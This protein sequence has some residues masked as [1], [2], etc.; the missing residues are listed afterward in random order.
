MPGAA[1]HAGQL[2]PVF[3]VSRSFL[4]RQ[5]H[6]RLPGRW[7][8]QRR[9]KRQL[10][11]DAQL[12]VPVRA[13]ELAV[14]REVPVALL[15]GKDT[16]RVRCGRAA[17]P[18][19]KRGLHARHSSPYNEPQHNWRWCRKCQGLFFAEM[20]RGVCPAGGGHDPTGSANYSITGAGVEANEVHHPAH[21]VLTRRYKSCSSTAT[22]HWVCNTITGRRQAHPSQPAT[23]TAIKL[24]GV[25]HVVY[26]GTD[27]Q[28]HALFI[29]STGR[30]VFDTITLLAG[31]PKAAGNPF[32]YQATGGTSRGVSRS[33]QPH[34]RAVHRFDGGH[35]VFNN[36][37][38]LR[39]RATGGGRP[40][41]L[42]RNGVHHVV[43]RGVDGQVHALFID[44]TAK[45]AH[46]T[47]DDQ[48]G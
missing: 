30:W 35:W 43:Y 7:I 11:G 48:R 22:G 9:R 34:P 24:G 26:R 29:N 25:H 45:W 20:G 2:A 31:A 32:G 36:D 13:A 15:R 18:E 4:R 27:S 5:Q 3:K 47:G 12:V 6:H 40:A 10:P 19:R 41:G 39:R 33:G 14:L 16:R 17:R 37:Y 44:S 46:N 21:Q 28:V 8:A 38:A 1:G 42:H 23:A